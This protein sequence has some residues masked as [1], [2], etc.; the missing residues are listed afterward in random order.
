[1]K[2]WLLNLLLFASLGLGLTACEDLNNTY[3]LDAAVVLLP[4]ADVKKMCNGKRACLWRSDRLIVMSP[5]DSDLYYVSFP[6]RGRTNLYIPPFG[7]EETQRALWIRCGQD[8]QKDLTKEVI[9]AYNSA[10]VLCHE[11]AHLVGREH[12]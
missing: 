8:V 7:S 5:D 11:V 3:Y 12:D 9:L 4:P 6:L 2:T 1:M 10:I